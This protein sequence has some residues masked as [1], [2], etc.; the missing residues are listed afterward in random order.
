MIPTITYFI[1]CYNVFMNTFKHE[2]MKNNTQTL[3]KGNS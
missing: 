2:H 3:M 1:S